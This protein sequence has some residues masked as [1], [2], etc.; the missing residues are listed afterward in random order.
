M[1][2]YSVF[3]SFFFGKYYSFWDSHQGER[4]CLLSCTK[5]WNTQGCAV[6]AGFVSAVE[7]SHRGENWWHSLQRCLYQRLGGKV[8]LWELKDADI[9]EQTR[10]HGV[11][12]SYVSTDLSVHPVKSNGMAEGETGRCIGVDDLKATP[13]LSL[14]SYAYLQ[15]LLFWSSSLK[16]FAIG[17]L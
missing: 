1:P 7:S 5:P 12:W 8:L 16:T 15:L 3:L 6:A 17:K 11:M 13:W 9:H 4:C 2:F 14:L 10:Q